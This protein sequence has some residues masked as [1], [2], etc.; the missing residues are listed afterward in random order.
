[1]AKAEAA[2][3]KQMWN[4][5]NKKQ[6]DPFLAWKKQPTNPANKPKNKKIRKK[7]QSDIWKKVSNCGIHSQE[8]VSLGLPRWH[9]RDGCYGNQ[10]LICFVAAPFLC[11]RKHFQVDTRFV[12]LLW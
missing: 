2:L 11:E 6:C 4:R 10:V 9:W 8:D 12:H 7:L 1:M 3:K 5:L